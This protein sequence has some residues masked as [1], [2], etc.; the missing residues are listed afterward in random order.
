MNKHIIKRMSFKGFRMMNKHLKKAILVPS[1]P[2]TIVRKT[3]IVMIKNNIISPT[4]FK[5][6]NNTNYNNKFNY[7]SPITR[8][9]D[10]FN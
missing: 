10:K 5:L 8:I 9:I 6:N 1:I 2:S 7:N 3:P 4:Y